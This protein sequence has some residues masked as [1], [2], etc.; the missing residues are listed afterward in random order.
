MD[1]NS[2]TNET[3][4]APKSTY[5]TLEQQ[6]SDM[7]MA[8]SNAGMDGIKEVML[9]VGYTPERIELMQAGVTKVR[10]LMQAKVKEDADQKAEQEVF[11]KKKEAISIP[12]VNHR[13]LVRI[14]FSADVHTSVSLQLNGEIPQAYPA[15]KEMTTNF[16]TQISNQPALLAKTSTV[17]ITAAVATAQ[18]AALTDLEATKSNL[19]KETAEAQAATQ[20]RDE[21]FDDI[22]PQ[23]IEYIKFAKVL[24]A[25]SPL[26]KALGV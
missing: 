6:V 19:K 11:D 2:Q 15:W 21:A 3:K 12:F 26:L 8:F 20:A 9:T 5:K 23:Y 10:T 14:Q 24:L 25:D 13:K 22:R 7:E 4:K 17:G 18:L 16:Y 1:T